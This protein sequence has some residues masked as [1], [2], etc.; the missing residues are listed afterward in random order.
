MI[1]M[2]HKH[3][4]PLA[5]L[6]CKHLTSAAQRQMQL[7]WRQKGVHLNPP[8]LSWFLPPLAPCLQ[9]TH[10]QELSGQARSLRTAAQHSKPA[11]SV[12]RHRLLECLSISRR[13]VQ[14]LS[15]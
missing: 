11:G 2:D 10:L 12:W 1:V 4:R 3:A 9:R 7:L 6:V 13:V 15:E 8:H 5:P 14:S